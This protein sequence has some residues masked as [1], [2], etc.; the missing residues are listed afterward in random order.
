MKKTTAVARVEREPVESCDDEI[1]I[2]VGSGECVP[3][4]PGCN[5]EPGD[6][7]R[8]RSFVA[9]IR[10][11]F[12]M[13][14]DPIDYSFFVARPCCPAWP[15]GWTLWVRMTD[16]S[17]T[18]PT[19]RDFPACDCTAEGLRAATAAEAMLRCVW[20]GEDD[21]SRVRASAEILSAGI[22][23]AERLRDVIREEARDGL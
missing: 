23:P 1:V 15:D 5:D 19:F 6:L 21:W 9:R 2:R 13:L 12:D 7:P 4:V 16:R 8:G 17:D 10:Y 3:V 14:G 18:K 11:G 20:R 22:I